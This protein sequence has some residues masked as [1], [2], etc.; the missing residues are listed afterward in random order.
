M[1]WNNW[2]VELT[3]AIGTALIAL[4]TAAF[5]PI[6]DAIVSRI[7]NAINRS[8]LQFERLKS[9]SSELSDYLFEAE[10][11]NE[12]FERGIASKSTLQELA[13]SYNRSVTT[14]RTRE[15]LYIATIQKFWGNS[16]ALKYESVVADIKTLD[17]AIHQANRE[18]ERL[19]ADATGDKLP[20]YDVKEFAQVSETIKSKRRALEKDS[21]EFLGILIRVK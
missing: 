10:N 1:N 18:L 21:K 8:E 2:W 14:I 11:I 6:S 5:T 7:K 12:M 3:A 19:L 15:Y 16:L 13:N 9:I 4:L 20:Q 17:K